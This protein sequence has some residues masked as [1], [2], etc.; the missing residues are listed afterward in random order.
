MSHAFSWYQVMNS[1]WIGEMHDAKIGLTG[2]PMK[3]EYKRLTL[4]EEQAGRS[5]AIAPKVTALSGG[6]KEIY[7][8]NA[9]QLLDKRAKKNQDIREK[10]PAMLV[11][12]VA[13]PSH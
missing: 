10:A 1:E 4:E 7:N 9:R 8:S 5:A 3:A 12:L 13:V 11:P 2:K 6:T